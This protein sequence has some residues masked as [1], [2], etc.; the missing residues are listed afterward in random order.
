MKTMAFAFSTFETCRY[1]LYRRKEVE[2]SGLVDGCG[3]VCRMYTCMSDFFILRLPVP[4]VCLEKATIR[5]TLSYYCCH[6]M[7]N[8]FS[9]G[10]KH[11][12]KNV[13]FV[14]EYISMCKFVYLSFLLKLFV[15]VCI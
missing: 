4:L 9:P 14:T 13:L 1:C 11:S 2:K 12:E 8:Q 10:A 5:N 7:K 6:S 15:Y 3:R